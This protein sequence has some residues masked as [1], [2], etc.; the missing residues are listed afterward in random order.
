M[1]QFLTGPIA[2]DGELSATSL[3]ANTGTLTSNMFSSSSSARLD[4][5]KAIERLRLI[6]EQAHGTAIVTRTIGM[7]I[8]KGAATVIQLKGVITG[9]IPGAD[10]ITVDVHRSTAGGAFATIMSGTMT[11][12]SADT[13]RVVKSSTSFSTTALVADDVLIWVITASGSTAQGLTA[14]LLL[15]EHPA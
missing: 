10:T 11:F 15:D 6:H 7:H 14:E 1:T 12:T 9:V 8:C 4:A 3:V 2:V 13:I 5:T